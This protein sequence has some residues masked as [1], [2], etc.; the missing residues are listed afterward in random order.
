[1]KDRVDNSVCPWY[2]GPSLIELLDNMPM[3]RNYR[4]A[5]LMP[6]ADKFKDMGTVVI[7]KIESGKVKKGQKVLIMPNKVTVISL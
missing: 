3:P 7:G 1:M 2:D 5:L 4:G 6:I